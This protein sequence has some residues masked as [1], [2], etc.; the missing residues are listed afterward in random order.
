MTKV[1]LLAH[2]CHYNYFT[3]LVKSTSLSHFLLQAIVENHY[4]IRVKKPYSTFPLF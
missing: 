4:S 3:S 1:S 2:L